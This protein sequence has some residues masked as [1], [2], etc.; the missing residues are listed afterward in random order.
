[1]QLNL[2]ELSLKINAYLC[3][4]AYTE[5]A[6]VKSEFMYDK[7]FTCVNIINIAESAEPRR[8]KW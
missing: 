6:F 7:F 5:G 1:M 3:S 2:V 4:L 8:K